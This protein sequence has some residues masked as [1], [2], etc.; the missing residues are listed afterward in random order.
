M[1]T[2]MKK[3]L[4]DWFCCFCLGGTK[5]KSFSFVLAGEKQYASAAHKSL[6]KEDLER[7]VDKLNQEQKQIFDRIMQTIR[8]Q[9]YCGDQAECTCKL[10]DKEFNAPIREMVTGVGGCGGYLIFS[11]VKFCNQ[12]SFFGNFLII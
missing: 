12:T 8:H 1:C 7:K 3:V 4:F 9:A 5:F 2:T 6:R 11:D 10:V